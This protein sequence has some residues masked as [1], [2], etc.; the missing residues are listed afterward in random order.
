[1]W[2][3]EAI[4]I[5]FKIQSSCCL[6]ESTREELADLGAWNNSNKSNFKM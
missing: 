2:P 5:Q 4:A 3:E 1:M 6:A